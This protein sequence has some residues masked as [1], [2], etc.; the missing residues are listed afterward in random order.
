MEEEA[1]EE[2]EKNVEEEEEA[3]EWEK[4]EEED[5][6]VAEEEE[7]QVGLRGSGGGRKRRVGDE[8]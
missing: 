8:E 7:E 3:E 4:N 5:E 1:E 2:W 6:E